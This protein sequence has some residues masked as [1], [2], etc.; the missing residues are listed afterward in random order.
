M[1]YRY[2]DSLTFSS[3]FYYQEQERDITTESIDDII[4]IASDRD[5]TFTKLDYNFYDVKSIMNAKFSEKKYG[6]KLKSNYNTTME[7]LS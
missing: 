3:T 6:V 4:I 1:K 5:H 7:T 2:N